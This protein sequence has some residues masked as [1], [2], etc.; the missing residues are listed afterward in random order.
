MR[1]LV[2]AL[3]RRTITSL[4][5]ITSGRCLHER[6]PLPRMIREMTVRGFARRT[7]TA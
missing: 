6:A 3:P 4:L 1:S 5:F 7:H 2:D